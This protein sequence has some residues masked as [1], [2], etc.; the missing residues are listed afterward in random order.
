MLVVILLYKNGVYLEIKILVVK[1]TGLLQ[2]SNTGKVHDN[3]KPALSE[4][5]R[6]LWEG[7]LRKEDDRI[8]NVGTDYP[9]AYPHLFQC[10]GTP[11][12]TQLMSCVDGATRNAQEKMVVS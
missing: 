9:A 4:Q 6:G 8:L 2:G 7:G 10:S 12:L 1:E 11:R 3:K 5:D